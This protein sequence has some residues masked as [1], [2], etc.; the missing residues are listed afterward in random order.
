ML[1]ISF[2]LG[3]LIGLYSLNITAIDGTTIKMSQFQGKK[4]LIVNTAS[5]SIYVNQY[6]SLEQLYEKYKD[7]LVIIAC[8]SNDFKN[9]TGSS[10]SIQNLVTTKYNI[11]YILTSKQVVTGK[12]ISPLYKWLSQSS[13]NGTMD[14]PVIGDFCK[15]LIDNKG[16]IIGVFS[17]LVDPMDPVI[18][19]AIVN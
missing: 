8:P 9:E 16:D 4:I 3:S 15:Y 11:H 5:N 1:N 12:N 7:S 18:Q 2:L 13:Q 14:G 17:D 6:A 10:V 19:N